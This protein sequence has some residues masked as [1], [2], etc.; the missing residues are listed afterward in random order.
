MTKTTIRGARLILVL[1][2]AAAMSACVSTRLP[3]P[4]ASADNVERL[5]TA[6]AG[7]AQVGAFK[8]APGKPASMDTAVGGL[9]G[10]T[11]FP[12]AGFYSQQ[13]REEL[14]AE[15][16]GAGLLD[17]SSAVVIEG[18]LTDNRVDAAMGAGTARLAAR[19]S[20]KRDGKVVFDKELAA[21]DRWESMIMGNVAIPAAV[22]H[23]AALYKTLVGKL[24]DDPEF[25]AAVKR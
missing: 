7:P 17:P 6:S 11:V 10:S 2:A 15:L 16:K 20:V 1:A 24:L 14:S 19:F 9:R 4:V 12:T 8:L 23:Y 25:R 18:L 21:E 5:R 3:P 22:N 13:L